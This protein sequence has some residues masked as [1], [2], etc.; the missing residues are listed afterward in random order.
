MR[1]VSDRGFSHQAVGRCQ[2]PR[3]LGGATVTGP[4]VR[5]GS[6]RGAGPR[7]RSP[8]DRGLGSPADRLDRGV[9]DRRHQ[10]DARRARQADQLQDVRVADRHR[11]PSLGTA[12]GGCR[13]GA[14]AA[15]RAGS[16]SRS[17][18]QAHARPARRTRGLRSARQYFPRSGATWR[19][20]DGRLVW[21]CSPRRCAVSATNASTRMHRRLRQGNVRMGQDVPL[22]RGNL[23]ELRQKYVV[24][25][26][27]RLSHRRWFADQRRCPAPWLDVPAHRKD[28]ERAMLG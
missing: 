15:E 17:S 5:A 18:T 9:I 1:G 26:P 8:A 12:A 2:P 6:V 19:W 14:G 28:R 13:P 20:P 3:V 4:T 27:D 10:V 11:G 21:M 25:G 16:S 22:S 24:T 23:E 7:P